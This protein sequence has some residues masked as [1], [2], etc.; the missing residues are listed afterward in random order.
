MRHRKKTNK[1][2][3]S[4]KERFRSKSV[5]PK[6]M[7][8]HP[9]YEF[10]RRPPENSEESVYR[11]VYAVTRTKEFIVRVN[12]LPTYQSH[13][14]ELISKENLP[15]LHFSRDEYRSAWRTAMNDFIKKEKKSK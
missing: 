4:R 14:S 8:Q 9:Q 6:A 3:S 15:N 5:A 10:M 12:S 1:S 7:T 11:S 2:Q 13:T